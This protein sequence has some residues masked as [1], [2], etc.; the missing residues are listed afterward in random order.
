[1]KFA[2]IFKMFPEYLKPFV[3]IAFCMRSS[4]KAF[5]F[6]CAY[7]LQPAISNPTGDGVS[8]TYVRGAF[9]KDGRPQ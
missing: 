7:D 3:T 4:L 6:C 9:S 2:T 1:M 8:Q 5:Q